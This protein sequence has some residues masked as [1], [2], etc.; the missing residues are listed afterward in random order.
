MNRSEGEKEMWKITY[1]GNRML[2]KGAYGKVFEGKLMNRK[3]RT[4]KKVAVKRHEMLR[5]DMSRTLV[6]LHLDH[7]NVVKLLAYQDVDDIFRYG[8]NFIVIYV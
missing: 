1:D 2:G 7:P 5:V 3:T 6:E 8:T 4:L